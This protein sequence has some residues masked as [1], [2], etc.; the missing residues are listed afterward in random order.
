MTNTFSHGVHWIG[1][2]LTDGELQAQEYYV[3]F[4]VMTPHTAIKQILDL[5]G[6]WDVREDWQ[7]RLRAPLRQAA[8]AMRQQRRGAAR[9]LLKAFQSRAAAYEEIDPGIGIIFVESAQ[10]IIEGLSQ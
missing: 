1:L 6:S 9:N 2:H 8:I 3:A 4:E 5:L 10:T 7:R